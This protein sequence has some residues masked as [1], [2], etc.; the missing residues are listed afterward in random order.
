M[1]SLELLAGP[2]GGG[3]S[4]HALDLLESGSV[5]ALADVTSIWAALSGA[6]RGPDGRY[7]ERED[8]DPTL[9]IAQYLQ[10]VIARE[11]LQR[12]VSVA[13]TTSRQGQEA[14]WASLAADSGAEFAETVID[15]GEDV[16]RARLADPETGELSEACERAIRR[17]YS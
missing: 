16:I 7:P 4:Q 6:Q 5:G 17:W 9:P 2:A 13:V 15:P 10:P 14:R 8:D 3:K 1:A 11:A 12:G